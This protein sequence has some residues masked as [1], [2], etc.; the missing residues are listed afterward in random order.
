M[1]DQAYRRAV[2]RSKL[3]RKYIKHIRE[4]DRRDGARCWEVVAYDPTGG[5]G[6]QSRVLNESGDLLA[7]I[8]KPEGT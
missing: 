6:P 7:I 3:P 8:A 5:A 4:V 1:N 2:N